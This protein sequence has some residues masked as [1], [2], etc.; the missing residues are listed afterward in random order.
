M[1]NR[2]AALVALILAAGAN[3]DTASPAAGDS[4]QIESVAHPGQL[5]RVEDARSA[6]GTPIV[7]YP[8]Q[9]WRCMTWELAAEPGGFRLRN[10]FTHKTLAPTTAPAA[11]VVQRPVAKS[12]TADEPWRFEPIDGKPGTFRIVHVATG[13]ALEAGE[14]DRIIATKPSD[15]PSQQWKLRPKPEHFT[16]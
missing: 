16:G 7:L 1:R 3:A 5:L 2:I 10:H 12:P 15:S 14:N 9:A 4:F 11:A 8:A 13:A 6:D